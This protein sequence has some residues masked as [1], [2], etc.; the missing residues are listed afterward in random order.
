MPWFLNPRAYEGLPFYQNPE[1]Y[2]FLAKA[3]AAALFARALHRRGARGARLALASWLGF[4][5]IFLVVMMSMHALVIIGMRALDRPAGTP[6]GYDF[7]L[8][9]LVLL[10]AVL[11]AQGV[12]L[13]GAARG[14]AAGVPGSRRAA[15]SALG[16]VLA[17]SAPLIPLQ[18]FGVLLTALSVASLAALAAVRAPQPLPLPAAAEGAS[19]RPE[20]AWAGR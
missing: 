9:S 5:G 4:L 10:A 20:A 8:Y 16:A 12:R 13:L 1:L 15:A 3:A 2:L 18:F 6:F 14:V 17:L 7:R 11:G 19:A